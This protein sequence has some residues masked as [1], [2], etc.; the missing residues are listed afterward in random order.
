M[1]RSPRPGPKEARLRLLGRRVV[2]AVQPGQGD[3]FQPAGVHRALARLRARLHR[4]RQPRRAEARHALPGQRL[5]DD[6]A[7]QPAGHRGDTLARAKWSAAATPQ[8]LTLGMN[9]ARPVNAV[10]A[11]AL[12]RP[13]SLDANDWRLLAFYSW[14]TDQQQVVAKDRL[15]RTLLALADAC[16]SR[17]PD[18]AM[19]LRLKALAAADAKAPRAASIPATR[20]PCSR[21][22]ATRS[23]LASRPTCSPTTRP[24]SCAP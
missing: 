20:R 6:G 24:R 3:H 15:P 18:T 11:D 22:W 16:P 4:R 10:L 13:A 14:D 23:G 1:P 2:P 19:R 7:V 5:P 9:A 12:G 17:R 21:C 8:V